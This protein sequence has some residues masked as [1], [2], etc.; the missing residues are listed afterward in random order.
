MDN[1]KIKWE[2]DDVKDEKFGIFYKDLCTSVRFLVILF[3]V[4]N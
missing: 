3:T 1:V 4:F 2:K